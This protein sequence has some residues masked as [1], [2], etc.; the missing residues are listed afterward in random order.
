MI[1]QWHTIY[2]WQTMYTKH[3]LKCMIPLDRGKVLAA[4]NNDFIIFSKMIKQNPHKA[5]LCIIPLDRS[6]V[7]GAAGGRRAAAP[8]DVCVPR[9]PARAPLSCP[10]RPGG[11]V[12]MVWR[13]LSFSP[14]GFY[15]YKLKGFPASTTNGDVIRR[16]LTATPQCTANR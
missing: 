11:P 16:T 1:K 4:D 5:S 7:L 15:V 8:R 10:R 6:M 2:H 12:P 9:V 14:S 3:G 13:T